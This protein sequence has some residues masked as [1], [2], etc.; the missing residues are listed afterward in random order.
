M[1]EACER[2]IQSLSAMGKSMRK[3][4][5]LGLAA[6]RCCGSGSNLWCRPC[7]YRHLPFRYWIFRLTLVVYHASSWFD[8]VLL[9]LEVALGWNSCGKIGRVGKPFHRPRL[10]LRRCQLQHRGQTMT[11]TNLQMVLLSSGP[12]HRWIRCWDCKRRQS[13]ARK[14]RRYSNHTP[15]L[16]CKT[17][18]SHF[19]FCPFFC[20]F[21]LSFLK[22]PV[23]QK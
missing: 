19:S 3:T 1:Q 17:T 18:Q 23:D 5:T 7:W 10:H 4:Y 20:F 21:F 6:E 11:A 15:I 13:S 2:G 16:A 14:N 12:L 8:S 9:H 22:L